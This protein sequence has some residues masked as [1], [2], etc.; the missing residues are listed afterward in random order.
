MRVA[1]IGAGIVGVTSAYELAGDGHDVTVFERRGSVAA[2]ASF[3]N[4][5]VVSAGRVASWDGTAQRRP[6]PAGGALNWL[7]HRWQAG[8]MRV[9]PAARLRT[10]RLAAFSR[11]R[12]HEISRHL[13]LD[14]E[15]SNGLLVLLRTAHDLAR[16]QADLASLAETHTRFDLLDAAQSRLLEPDLNPQ[17][18]LHA[19]VHL[20]DSEVGNCR[21]FANLLRTEAQRIGVRFH[22]H[23]QVQRIEAGTVP[24]LLH[25]Y[26]PPE[27]SALPSNPG[28]RPA[29]N[30][31]HDTQPMARLPVTQDFD[32]VVVCAAVGSATLLR[33]LGLKLPLRA[34]YGYAVTA[35]LRRHD[36]H[37]DHGPRSALVDEQRQVTISRL[38]SRL[39]VTGAAVI[40]G[41]PEHHDPRALDALYQ[42]LH[43][44]FP[45]SAHLSQAQTWKGA[46]PTLPDGPPVLGRSG[47]DGVWLNLG[48]GSNG[49][50][51]ACGCAR[52]LAD[53]IAGRTPSMPTEGLGVERF[54][55]GS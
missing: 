51:L 12:L 4:A 13:K 44:W 49:W 2:E 20:P 52:L 26:V 24:R 11:E 15:H 55:G 45:G 38:G 46:R 16:V 48:H 23:T 10:Q 47:I 39:R 7:L 18:P 50:A 19:A 53:G 28:A 32:A 40:G 17:T 33:P 14:Y 9:D 36:G 8:R 1:V 30:D 54:R 35:P 27:D 5:G 41:A 37:P 29:S 34:V 21:Q 25:A 22:F 42:V 3:A 43:D 6:E 31:A